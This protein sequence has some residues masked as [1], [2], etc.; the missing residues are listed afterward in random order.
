MSQPYFPPAP[1]SMSHSFMKK[2]TLFLPTYWVWSHGSGR[3]QSFLQGQLGSCC[4]GDLGF[5]AT[6]STPQA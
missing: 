2:P 5:A 1:A 6:G 4:S 3:R